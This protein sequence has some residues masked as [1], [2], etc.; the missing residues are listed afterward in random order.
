MKISSFFFALFS[1]I[2]VIYI[3]EIGQGLILPFFIALLLWVHIK[4]LSSYI[5]KI[6]LIKRNL[7]PV[8]LNFFSLIII[9]YFLY[10]IIRFLALN[11]S[12]LIDK[13]PDYENNIT[14]LLENIK[15]QYNIDL[16]GKIKNY[17]NDFNIANFFTLIFNSLYSLFSDV[18]II[19]LYTI[20]LILEDAVFIKKLRAI[21]EDTEKYERTRA[22]IDQLSRAI[23]NYFSLKTLVC[24]TS[25]I[26]NWIIL[27]IIGL[28][29]AFFVAFLVFLLNYIPTIGTLTAVIIPC[30]FTLLQFNDFTLFFIIF[31]IIGGF[32]VFLGNFLEPKIMGHSLNIS[33]LIVIITLLFWGS[34]WGILG[35]ILSVPITVMLIIIFAQFR[36][37]RSIA[38]LLSEKGTINTFG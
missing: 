24:L 14:I 23:Y 22:M 36:Q 13:I 2:A 19:F 27:S 33:P 25:G 37:T 26:V 31:A 8:I 5:S 32:Q 29:F 17:V 7:H 38:I 21:F 16:T 3:L 1:L 6:P 15:K 34:I 10:V 18:F 30:M 28:E 9:S 35:M 11:I 4:V 12:E 20:F